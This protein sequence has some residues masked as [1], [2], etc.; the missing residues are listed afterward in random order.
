M[1]DIVF[2]HYTTDFSNLIKIIEDGEIK[3]NKNI[4]KKRRKLT[5]GQTSE[6][7]F[8]NMY[9]RKYTKNIND[10]YPFSLIIKPSII[11]S[12]NLHFNKGWHGGLDKNSI[13][14]TQKNISKVIQLLNN[15][16]YP[17]FNNPPMPYPMTNEVLTKKNINIKEH[18]KAII[19]NKQFKKKLIKVLKDNNLNIKVI[20]A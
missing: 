13:K 18:V 15:E 6:Y 3:P 12:H 7:I 20:T 10:F 2:T 11:K 1:K 9:V 16:K 17:R 4:N 19:I 8:M 5:G 14:I